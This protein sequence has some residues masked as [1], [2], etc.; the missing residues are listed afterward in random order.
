LKDAKN[1]FEIIREVGLDSNLETYN[2]MI[3][4]LCESQ[5]FDE[6]TTLME[7]MTVKGIKPNY[8]TFHLLINQ[9][10]AKE[11]SKILINRAAGLGFDKPSR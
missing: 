8:E 2:A 4:P 9:A 3:H 11:I 7:E 1:I 5:K 10:D 6:A